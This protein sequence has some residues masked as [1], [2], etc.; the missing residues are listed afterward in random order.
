MLSIASYLEGNPQSMQL[1][2][3]PFYYSM[4]GQGLIPVGG[5]VGQGPNIMIPTGNVPG[6]G[7]AGSA[8]SPVYYP[9]MYSGTMKD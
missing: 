2:Q 5:S 3:I 9:G 6:G 4:N 1:Q 8:T 7:A